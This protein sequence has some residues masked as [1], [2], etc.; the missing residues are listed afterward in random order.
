MSRDEKD[1]MTD[2][3]EGGGGRREENRWRGN[4]KPAADFHEW[5]T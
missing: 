1:E 3:E 4:D 2:Q 5:M